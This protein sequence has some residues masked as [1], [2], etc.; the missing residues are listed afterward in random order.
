MKT[1]ASCNKSLLYLR[2]EKNQNNTPNQDIWTIRAFL[3]LVLQL[4]HANST[5]KRRR[6]NARGT[7]FFTI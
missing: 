7:H 2:A 1:L 4:I 5:A 6:W 3:P